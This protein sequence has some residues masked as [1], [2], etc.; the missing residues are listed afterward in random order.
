MIITLENNDNFWERRKGLGK[1][2]VSS[3][4]TRLQQEISISAVLCVGSASRSYSDQL[5]D[6]DIEVI[7][8]N[9]QPISLTTDALPCIGTDDECSVEFS[10]LSVDDLCAK[11]TS[12]KDIDHW[13]YQK[14]ALLAPTSPEVLLAL[15]QMAEMP[16]QVRLDRIKLHYWEYLFLIHRFENL[17]E[18]GST[19]NLSAVATYAIVSISKVLFLDEKQWP[20]LTHW[21]EHN[22]LEL[23]DIKKNTVHKI[24]NFLESPTTSSCRELILSMNHELASRPSLRDLLRTPHLALTKLVTSSDFRP[25]REGYGVF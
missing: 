24:K 2:L 20:P 12:L 5:S 25:I 6:I 3:H 7:Y 22:L 1:A 11:R 10:F 23:Q 15:N 9:R 8:D 18:R 14:C 21:L 17:I 4:L 19:I 16:L 13:P